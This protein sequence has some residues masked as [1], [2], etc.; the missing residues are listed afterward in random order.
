M[1]KIFMKIKNEEGQAMVELAITL[2]ILLLIVCGIIEFG[3]IFSNQLMINNSSREGARYA[4]TVANKSNATQLITE[5]VMQTL[6]AGTTGNVSVC[7]NISSDGE[8]KVTV[9]RMLTALTPVGSLLFSGQTHDLTSST[10]ML[11]G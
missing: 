6:P 11:A 1:K 5:K 4:I 7:V 2:P 9:V 8:A 10:T 3:W